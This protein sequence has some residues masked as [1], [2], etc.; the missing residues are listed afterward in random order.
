MPR[1]NRVA[2][3]YKSSLYPSKLWKTYI[4]PKKFEQFRNQLLEKV[5]LLFKDLTSNLDN[6][7]SVG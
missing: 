2:D 7:F 1:R 5:I 3:Y 6:S 4:S